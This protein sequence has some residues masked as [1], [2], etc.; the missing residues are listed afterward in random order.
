MTVAE[1]IILFHYVY[2]RWRGHGQHAKGQAFWL[3]VLVRVIVICMGT[4]LGGAV[5]TT[6][7]MGG[8][9]I[10]DEIANLFRLSLLPGQFSYPIMRYIIL[11][12]MH[13]QDSLPLPS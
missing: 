3:G 8:V 7:L 9:I 2:C 5:Q 13:A 6:W 10:R 4:T 12:D 11:P 1:F